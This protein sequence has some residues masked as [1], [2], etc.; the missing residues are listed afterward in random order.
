MNLQTL[1]FEDKALFDKYLS[2]AKHDLRYYAFSNIFL[3]K[4]MYEVRWQIFNNC[5][6][7][8]FKD[9]HACFMYLPPLGNKVMLEV[10]DKCFNIMNENNNQNCLSQI[11]NVEADRAEFFSKLNFEV[12]KKDPDYV[13]LRHEL[14]SL[15]GDRYKAKRATCNYF[16]KNFKSLYQPYTEVDEEE[17]V[18]LCEAWIG[19]RIQQHQDGL[20]QAML[21]DNLK[22]FKYALKHLKVLDLIG[23]VLRVDGRIVGYT[24]GYEVSK[25][26]FCVMFEVCDRD[27][28]GASQFIFREFCAEF[29]SYKYIN[30]MDDSGLENLKIVKNLYHPYR[31]IDNL[32]V[33]QDVE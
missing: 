1:S 10:I 18:F 32:V 12:K 23:R 15:Q 25:D 28:K 5:L 7:V 26:M 33:S 29:D 4:S 6:C 17:C 9:E 31:M 27:F 11:E 13:Y 3:W 19:C 20:Y 22:I 14:V 30:T 2:L 8:F 21:F 16:R 24:F